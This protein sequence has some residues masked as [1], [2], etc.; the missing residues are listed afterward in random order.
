M[1]TMKSVN[2]VNPLFNETVC[3]PDSY[4]EGRVWVGAFAQPILKILLRIIDDIILPPKQKGLK[5]AVMAFFDDF[6]PF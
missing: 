2:H 3:P 4:R 6:I 5:S 1:L